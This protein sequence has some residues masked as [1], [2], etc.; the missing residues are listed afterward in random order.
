ME[1]QT[2]WKGQT[3]TLMIF[4]GIIV[5]CAIFFVL[6][7]LVGRSQSMKGATSKETASKEAP[8]EPAPTLLVEP[9]AKAEPAPSRVPQVVSDAP[10]VSAKPEPLTPPPAAKTPPPP[11]ARAPVVSNPNAVTF[12]ISALRKSADAEKQVD[13]LRKKGFKA[14]ILAPSPGDPNPLYRVQVGPIGDP[15]EAESVRRKL[16]SAGY[17]PIVKSK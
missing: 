3:F 13:D 12:Q 1:E 16:E 15:T 11:P 7:T 5:L 8:R 17:K 9:A 10:P 2:T 14:L 6:G 4:G